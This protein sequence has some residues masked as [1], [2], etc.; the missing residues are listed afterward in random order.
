MEAEFMA[1]IDNFADTLHTAVGST[2]YGSVGGSAT[3]K[4][5]DY[6]TLLAQQ[7]TPEEIAARKRRAGNTALSQAQNLA[8]ERLSK[9]QAAARKQGM[10]KGQAAMFGGA[11]ANQNLASDYQNAYNS[12]L[13]QEN[14]AAE[15]QLEMAK[16]QYDIAMAEK[17]DKRDTG[18]GIVTSILG[19]LSD[20][21]LK[22]IYDRWGK[23]ARK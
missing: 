9:A 21:R 8:G 13:R 15:Q 6:Q 3:Q 10:T 2:L 1:D 4:A 14:L 20:E 17:K 22:N 18:L 5:K 12:A 19:I 7:G 23:E 11:Q 16:A